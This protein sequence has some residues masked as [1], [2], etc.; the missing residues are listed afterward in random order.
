MFL[1]YS[2]IQII[3]NLFNF[4][5]LQPNHMKDLYI[6]LVED[7]E[8]DAELLKEVFEKYRSISINHFLNGQSFLDGLNGG[9]PCLIIL[10]INLPDIQLMD[11]IHKIR[12]NEFL[13]LIPIMVYST[14][15]SPSQQDSCERYNIELFKK[16]NTL[17]DW[18]DLALVMAMHCDHSLL[19][20]E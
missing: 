1:T 5:H 7:D 11:M 16:P 10:D 14:N 9:L 4:V 6:A 17:K 12:A 15:F 18:D 3:L 2:S 13:S 19:K 20:Q 8:D